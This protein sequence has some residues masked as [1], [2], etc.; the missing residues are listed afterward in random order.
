MLRRVLDESS[1]DDSGD[2]GNDVDF[3]PSKPSTN[4]NSIAKPIT[5]PVAKEREKQKIYTLEEAIEIVING[6]DVE[7]NAEYNEEQDEIDQVSNRVEGDEISHDEIDQ[8]D[9]QEDKEVV[10][11]SDVEEDGERSVVCNKS[12]KKKEKEFVWRK[13]SFERPDCQ[14]KHDNLAAEAAK[15]TDNSSPMQLLSKYFTDHLFNSI[16]EETNNRYLRRTG[17]TLKLTTTE[18]RQFFGICCIMGNL[19][20]PRLRMYWQTSY[21]IALVADT[22]PQKR[23]LQLYANLAA[24]SNEVPPAN[25]T[26]KY[27]KVQ[28][29]VQAIRSACRSLPPEENYSIDE[30]MIPFHGR[31]PARQYVKGKPNPVGIK[32]FV[33]CGKSGKAYDF[34]LYQGKGTGV[35]QDFRHLGLGGSVV[36]RLV[37]NLQ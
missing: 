4:A 13:K 23:F 30:Q 28:P 8:A 32:S 14:W 3:V 6:S 31:V 22:M 19:K 16:A 7:D 21:I 25:N 5:K 27:W 10:N 20:F 17:N 15:A 1:S 36:M 2:E 9:I 18:I 11:D 37:E 24:T 33:R 12:S 35:S 34:E 29:V 26:N